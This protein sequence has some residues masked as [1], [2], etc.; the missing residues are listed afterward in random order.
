MTL[1]DHGHLLGMGEGFWTHLLEVVAL[2][3]TIA[4]GGG[5]AIRAVKRRREPPGGAE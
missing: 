1:F 3:L 5:L 4:A 2:A